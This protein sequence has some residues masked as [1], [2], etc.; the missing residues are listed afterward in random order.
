MKHNR[1]ER[2]LVIELFADL[3]GLSEGFSALLIKSGNVFRICFS[4]EK[5]QP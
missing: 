2:I 4:V 5:D 3:G 1:H